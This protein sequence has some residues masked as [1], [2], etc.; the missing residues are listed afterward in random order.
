MFALAS[1]YIEGESSSEDEYL[2]STP[3]STP[4]VP[5]IEHTLP[6]DH[7]MSID[8]TLPPVEPNELAPATPAAPTSP[9]AGP[10]S[11]APSAPASPVSSLSLLESSNL[12]HLAVTHNRVDIIT[13]ILAPLLPH[14]QHHLLHPSPTTPP[15]SDYTTPTTTT[16]DSEI[17]S[18]RPPKPPLT[19]AC[20]ALSI[21]AA[22]YL[23]SK[24]ADPSFSGGGAYPSPWSLACTDPALRNV[25]FGS[26]V[27]KCL[28]SD[29]VKRIELF[30]RAGVKEGDFVEFLGGT[31]EGVEKG[32][33][34]MGAVEC[35]KFLS[36]A[37]TAPPTSA[38]KVR[39]TTNDDKF[40]Q[41]RRRKMRRPSE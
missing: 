26:E 28:Q 29:D 12:L 18:T 3:K 37:F 11:Q 21:P 30:V 4:K 23:L 16:A 35:A 40:A 17:I 1:G 19:I 5:L 22:A 36:E 2:P 15:Y 14:Q 34:E 13:E 25:A 9:A 33:K 27:L 6:I 31:E 41:V 20:A 32:C 38:S 7:T 10:S 39:T 8:H 24:S